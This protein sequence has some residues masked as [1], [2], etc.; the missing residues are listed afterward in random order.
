M[1][2]LEVQTY[3]GHADAKTTRRYLHYRPRTD[4]A[5]RLAKAFTIEE[6]SATEHPDAV[7]NQLDP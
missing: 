5:K 7:L 1:D 6:P 2:P 3:L 4:E